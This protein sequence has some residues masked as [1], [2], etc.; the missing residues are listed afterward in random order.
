MQ[1][2]QPIVVGFD[3]SGRA[4]TAVVWAAREAA[5]RGLPLK[6]VHAIA[7]P[8]TRAT[9]EVDE[10]EDSG[11]VLA[12]G[13]RVARTFLADDLVSG[14][15]VPGHAAGVLAEESLRAALVVVGQRT[16]DGPVSSAVG[17]TSLVLADR[18]RCPV[19]VARGAT[20]AQR[21]MLP[22]VVSACGG[23]TS[24][25]VLDFAAHTARLRGVP[26]SIVSAWSLPPGGEWSRAAGGFDSVADWVR[27]RATSALQAAQAT[28]QQ[29]R[30][31]CPTVTTG[32]RVERRDP[33]E[34]LVRSSR[35]AGLVVVGSAR[36][37]GLGRMGAT[38]LGLAACPVAVVPEG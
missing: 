31:S 20:D 23:T 28:E 8:S 17:S 38:V 10:P 15:C 21:A 25:V 1:L 4:R 27:A 6:L 30:E 7:H 24:R 26:L 18:A 12:R 19:V 36:P 13:L 9:A 16:Q 34:A 22:V 2:G 33:A 5:Q 11:R 35:R 32:M 37:A 29:V 3:G 14:V